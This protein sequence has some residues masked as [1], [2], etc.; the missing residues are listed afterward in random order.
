MRFGTCVCLRNPKRFALFMLSE[1]RN[2]RNGCLWAVLS[3]IFCTVVMHQA[4]GGMP[5]LSIYADG[6]LLM[7]KD[8]DSYLKLHT[9]DPG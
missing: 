4:L 1:G 8:K 7:S 9:H 5:G 2:T 3:R 6:V